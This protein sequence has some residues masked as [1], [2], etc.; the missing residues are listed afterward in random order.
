M[1]VVTFTERAAAELVRRIRKLLGD[2]LAHPT[3]QTANAPAW[4]VD[5]AARQRLG[6]AIESAPSAAI[7][8]IHA[9]CHRVLTEHAFAGGRLLAQTQVESRT[10][11]SLAFADVLR[12]RLATDPELSPY[13]DAWLG[14]SNVDGLETLL[15]K[16]RQQRCEWA[17]SLNPSRLRA[18]ARV[19]LELPVSTIQAVVTRGAGRANVARGIINR[20]LELRRAAEEL[21]AT[22]AAPVSRPRRH[23]GEGAGGVRLGRRAAGQGVRRIPPWPTCSPVSTP[24]PT[25]RSRW[26]P[27]SRS[28]SGPWWRSG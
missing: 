13:L 24:S 22:G 9:F 17:V 21:E 14:S 15:Y 10:A 8:T 2:V 28:G 20:L 7:S 11:F 6:V 16:A 5:D 19:F 1:L 27:S 26:P 18:A 12:R 23:V 25:R 3:G 4:V